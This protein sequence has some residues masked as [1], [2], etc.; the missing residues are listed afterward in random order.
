MV[1]AGS[2]SEGFFNLEPVLRA[3]RKEAHVRSSTW[4]IFPAASALNL[5][6]HAIRR[7]QAITHCGQDCMRCD[8][9]VRGGPL[10]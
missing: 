1:E 9:A 3:V 7:N 4:Q 10:L 5:A 2:C 8:D 6:T